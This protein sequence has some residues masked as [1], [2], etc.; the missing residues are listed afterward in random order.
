MS[1]MDIYPV[2]SSD[3]EFQE[4]WFEFIDGLKEFGKNL[5]IDPKDYGHEPV[6]GATKGMPSWNKGIPL[7]EEHKKNL[8]KANKGQIQ[9]DKQ[10]KSVSEAAKRTMSILHTCSK[11]GKQNIIGNHKRW[12]E[13]NCGIRKV[14]SSNDPS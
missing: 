8:S 9:S 4:F 2:N 14:K 12:H 3:G 13:D 1:A 11:C 10:R 7:S 5:S 6:P